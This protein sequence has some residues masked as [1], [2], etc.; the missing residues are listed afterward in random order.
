MYIT[1]DDYASFYGYDRL[2]EEMFDRCAMEAD[3]IMDNY[4]TGVDGYRK[5]KNAF[6]TDE[7]DARSVKFCEARILDII[8]QIAEANEASRASRQQVQTANG[9]HSSQISSMSSGN[10]S[11][12]YVTGVSGGDAIATAA[13]DTGAKA[14]LINEMLR[15]TLSGITDANGVNL[16]YL[17]VYPHV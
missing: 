13:A 7:E 2:P 3:R 15:G 10:E 9:S 4:T 16:L 12:S 5:L 11:V 14:K 6:P 17:G 1:Y 8:W